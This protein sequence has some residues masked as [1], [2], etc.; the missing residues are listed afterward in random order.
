MLHLW[1]L[2]L[3][4]LLY[5]L[6]LI[7]FNLL[8]M[9]KIGNRSFWLYLLLRL[10]L[11]L[12]RYSGRKLWK[13]LGCINWIIRLIRKVSKLCLLFFIS[14]SILASSQSLPPFWLSYLKQL[15]KKL[16]N[17]QVSQQS[18][19]PQSSCKHYWLQY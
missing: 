5:L 16:W 12:I 14:H 9:K 17:H 15:P 2:L 7:G 8:S 6:Y 19:L 18:C 3:V 4:L 13:W 10:C 11:G 1:Y